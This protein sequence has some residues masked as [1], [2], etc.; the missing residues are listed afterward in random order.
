[1]KPKFTAD[2]PGVVVH[3]GADE[4]TLRAHEDGVVRSCIDTP[5]VGN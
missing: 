4:P 1:M 3:E 5:N 2:Y